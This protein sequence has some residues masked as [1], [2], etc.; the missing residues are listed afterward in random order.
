LDRLG[1]I[2]HLLNKK[3]YNYEFL[4]L[5]LSVTMNRSYISSST[6]LIFSVYRRIDTKIEKK[7]VKFKEKNKIK[8]IFYNILSFTV[9][10]FNLFI[11]LPSYLQKLEVKSYGIIKVGSLLAIR[12]IAF[13]DSHHAIW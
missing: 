8:Y 11:I 4:S 5:S 1:K 9:Y 7:N 2:Y 12:F 6:F 10:L 3:F 13:W